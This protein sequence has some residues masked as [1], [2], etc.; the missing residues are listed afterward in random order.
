MAFFGKFLLNQATLL[1]MGY[2]IILFILSKY[3]FI[4]CMG[5]FKATFDSI[6]RQFI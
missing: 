2:N 3:F 4:D 5:Y 6:D 1:K